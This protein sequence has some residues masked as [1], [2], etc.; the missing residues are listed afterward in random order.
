MSDEENKENMKIAG[1]K[2]TIWKYSYRIILPCG[3]VF[4]G[5]SYSKLR[6]ENVRNIVSD[7]LK[8]FDAGKQAQLKIIRES[9]EIH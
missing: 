3:T 1:C 7:V 2:V 4:W 8:V 9:L 5:T 6:T